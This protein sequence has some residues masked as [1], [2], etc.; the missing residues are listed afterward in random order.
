MEHY[1]KTAAS[2]LETLCNVKSNRRTGSQGNRQATDFFAKTIRGFGYEVDAADFPVLDHVCRGAVLTQGDHRHEVF[3]SPYSLGCDVMGDIIT[4][5]TLEELEQADGAGKVLLLHGLICQEQLMPK[6]FVFYNPDHHK[7]IISRLEAMNPLAIITATRTNPDLVGALDPFPLITDG[8]FDI[9]SVYCKDQTAE[10]I[11]ALPDVPVHLRI[12]AARLPSRAANVTAGL[13]MEKAGKIVLTAH[14]DAYEATPGAL[15][16]ASGTAVLL[17]AAEM[18]ADYRGNCRLEIL[19]LNGEDHYSAAGQM[20]YL[21]RYGNDLPKVAA[22]INIDDVGFKTGGSAYSC[23]GCPR[24]LETMAEQVFRK[25]P[26]LKRGAEWFNGDHM[27]FV[28]NGVPAIAI[29][30]EAME[31]LMR[32]VT[33]TGTDTPDLINCHKLVEIA[34]ALN[35]LVRAL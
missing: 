23:Y 29:T 18:L 1:E 30:A 33:H 27:A 15:D 28:Q 35:E 5:T 4:V 24:E 22:V 19:A 32:T 8:D 7:R 34:R 13:N 17:L 16:N 20:D 2:Y 3:V 26:G 25:Y 9:L 11:A 10:A 14:I 6:N 31:E 12:D 21:K